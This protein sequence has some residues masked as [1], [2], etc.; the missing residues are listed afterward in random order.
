M[1]TTFT[2]ILVVVLAAGLCSSLRAEESRETLAVRISF[3]HR[4]TDKVTISPQLIAG[5]PGL[6]VVTTTRPITVGAGSL[7]SVTAEVSWKKPE[8]PLRKPH[9]IWQY[10][11]EHGTPDQIARLKD[12][13]GLTPEAPVLTVLTAADGTRGFSIGLEQLARHKAMWLPEHDAFV[14]LADA[15]VD[16]AVHLAS[17]QGERVLDRVKREPEATLAEWTR[18]MGRHRQ[19]E[20]VEQAL[21]NVLAR[22]QGTS[23]RHCGPARFAL[24]VRR[25]PLGQRAARSRLAAQVPLRS[26]LARLP[27]DGAAHRQRIARHRHQLERDG[28]R[29]EIEQFAAPLGAAT[30]GT[31][32]RRSPASS[33]PESRLAGTGPVTLWL[34]PGDGEQGSSSR[35]ARRGR[36]LRAS[37]TARRAPCG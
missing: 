23:H 8:Q 28:Q 15:P 9:E 25:G 11:L 20:P 2:R 4:A 22:H 30:A 16:F 7:E 35:T 3:G 10:L 5:T 6:T 21:G 14:T 19:S 29:C 36:S 34:S 32:W 13:P 18:Q 33:S 24:Q 1:N 37:W 27:V 31:A 17:L 12:D 26:T